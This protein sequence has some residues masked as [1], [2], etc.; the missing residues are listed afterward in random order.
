MDFNLRVLGAE[1]IMVDSRLAVKLAEGELLQRN[2]EE[3]PFEKELNSF[4]RSYSF[5]GLDPT[6]QSASKCAVTGKTSQCV[7]VT[8]KPREIMLSEEAYYRLQ[9]PETAESIQKEHLR[10]SK[11][12]TPVRPLYEVRADYADNRYLE[13]IQTCTLL[14][15]SL[16]DEAERGDS[17]TTRATPEVLS[18]TVWFND[19]Q[20]T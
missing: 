18:E 3:L 6:V 12:G 10:K 20:P 17:F 14:L 7:A 16:F 1:T 13:A 4:I 19:F 11:D 5:I 9:E 8:V 2:G 15:S